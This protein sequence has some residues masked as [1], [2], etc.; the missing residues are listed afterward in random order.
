MDF[1]RVID[2]LDGFLAERR[3]SFVVIGGVALAAYGMPRLTLDVDLAVDAAAQ[4]ELVGF[5]ERLG[6]QTLHRS[7]RYS[8]HLHSDEALGRVDVVYLRGETAERVFAPLLAGQVDCF[9]GHHPLKVVP[10]FART[11]DSGHSFI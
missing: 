7:N 5:L 11:Q 1:E 4:E 9:V 8:N 3:R 10:G 6:Y 2:L